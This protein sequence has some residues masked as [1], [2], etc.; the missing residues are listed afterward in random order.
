MGS[1]KEKTLVGYCNLYCKGRVGG[2]RRP[3]DTVKL[4]P[5]KFFSFVK[6]FCFPKKKLMFGV[7]FFQIK[8]KFMFL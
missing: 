6:D 1:I 3:W 2:D 7:N 8:V 4:I 5:Q